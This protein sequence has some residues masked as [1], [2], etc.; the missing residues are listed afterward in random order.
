MPKHLADKVVDH[1]RLDAQAPAADVLKASLEAM[2][3]LNERTDREKVDA[4]IGAY[5][6][7]GLGVVGP[8]D[9][10]AALV[11]GQVDELLISAT[12]QRMQACRSARHWVGQRCAA[13]RTRDRNGL[14]GRSRRAAPE[15]VRLA[16]E[17]ITKAKQTGGADHVHRR[18]RSCSRITAASP[19]CCGSGF[20]VPR[21][22]GRTVAGAPRRAA[23]P[24]L[25][26]A[27]VSGHRRNHRSDN[28]HSRHARRR[29]S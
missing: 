2:Q 29:Q 3:R 28:G 13:G 19:R 18:R 24:A 21:V 27:P 11:N 7:G 6:A 23:A 9:T 20:D 15:V 1:V 26:R 25:L 14:G 12:M 4:A 10:L 22:G 17:L 5:R 8:E 16:D